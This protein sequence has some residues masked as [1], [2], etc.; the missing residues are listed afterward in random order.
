VGL[1]PSLRVDTGVVTWD[2]SAG[3]VLGWLHFSGSQFDRTSD[4]DGFELGGFLDLRV[5]SRGRKAGVFGLANL[6]FYPGDFAAYAKGIDGQWVVP[7][8][9]LG[10][11]VGLWLSP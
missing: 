10:L 2:A 1:G 5:S 7:K 8:L 6:Q 3:P 4:Q 9:S 11:A